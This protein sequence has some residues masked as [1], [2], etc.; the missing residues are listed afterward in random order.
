MAVHQLSDNMN[1]IVTVSVGVF[2]YLREWHT[3]LA[4]C[5]YLREPHMYTAV[6]LLAH[7]PHGLWNDKRPSKL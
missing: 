7:M 4:T 2:A 6:L 3:K 5:N 1:V